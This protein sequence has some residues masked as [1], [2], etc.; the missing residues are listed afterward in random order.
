MCGVLVIFSKKNVLNKKRCNL[1]FKAIKDRGPDFSLSKYFLKDRL[2][3][4]NT[5]LEVT[6]KVDK[7]KLSACDDERFYIS[8]NGEIYNYKNLKKLNKFLIPASNDTS[9]LIKLH[10]YN[11]PINILKSIEGMFAYVVYD[12]QKKKLY[13]ATDTQ[14]E[15]KLF[16]YEDKNY[17]ILSSNVNSILKFFD[18]DFDINEQQILD[19]LNTRHFLIDQK[20]FY[21]KI[22][23]MEGSFLYSKDLKNYKTKK[24]NFENP[25]NWI[26]EKYYKKLKSNNEVQNLNLLDSLFKKYSKLF[27]PNVNFGSIFTGGIDSS[28]QASY[29]LKEKKL[30]KLI[31]VDHIKKDKITNN[32]KKFEKYTKK[33]ITK[34]LC[35]EKIYYSKLAEV[36]KRLCLPFPSHDVVGHHLV[37]NFF[38]SKKIKVSFG[39]SGADELF[40]GYEAYKNI[41]WSSKEINNPSPY[42]NFK[43]NKYNKNSKISKTSTVLW[44]KA[45]KKYSKFLNNTDAKIQAS[46]FTDYFIQGIKRDNIVT[47]IISMSHGVEVRNI[48]LNKNIIKF[49]L[50]LPVR[51]KINLNENNK[52][53]ICKPLLKKLFI[54]KFSS[55][56]LFEKQGFSGFPNESINHAPRK[57]QKEFNNISKLIFKKSKHTKF[58]ANEWK[59]LNLF[60]FSKF[61]KRKINIGKFIKN[62]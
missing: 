1:S 62:I 28:L 6:G 24:Q 5:I 3:I 8:Y 21:K 4:G 51:Y 27:R 61:L 58:R 12:N 45:F 32:I 47:D 35:N 56:L 52:L 11:S 48:F 55:N 30:K 37:Y 53:L 33:K 14:G 46:L 7:R 15:K 41:N 59:F 20:T 36:Y 16:R 54:R 13:Y 2:F 31:C 25:L 34:I 44:K 39:A 50:N 18:K 42:S 9:K 19:Y 60:Y 23:L 10:K 43:S 38:K 57:D 49:C 17:F 29:F 26:D 40:G 22:E